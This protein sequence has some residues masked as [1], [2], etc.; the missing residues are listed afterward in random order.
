MLIEQFS[1]QKNELLGLTEG[2][3]PTLSPK[4]HEWLQARRVISRTMLHPRPPIPDN[5]FRRRVLTLVME[6]VF[7]YTIMALICVNVFFMCLRYEGK[8]RTH[9]SI[10]EVTEK[11]DIFF[12]LVYTA[13]AVLKNIGL[14]PQLYMKDNWNRFDLLLVVASWFGLLDPDGSMPGFNSLRVLRIG[15]LFRLIKRAKSLQKLFATLLYALPSLGNVGVF[16]IIIFFIFGVYRWSAL[17]VNLFGRL[18]MDCGGA[19]MDSTTGNFRNL[20]YAM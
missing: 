17:S 7:D 18:K 20:H 16:L 3:R 19:C 5:K 1:V 9:E 12:V 15:R 8:G 10:T 2:G 13:E 11:V 4:Q 14:T 6:P